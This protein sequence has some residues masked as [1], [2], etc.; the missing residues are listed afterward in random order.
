MNHKQ[1]PV[2]QGPNYLKMD[3][4]SGE[5]TAKAHAGNECVLVMA[6]G[7]DPKENFERW[8]QLTLLPEE[9]IRVAH[10]ML[11]AAARASGEVTA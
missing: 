7:K 11:N 4:R 2:K 10:E 8:A 9:A 1:A 6:H 3:G 5:I